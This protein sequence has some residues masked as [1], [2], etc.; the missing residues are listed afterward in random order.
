MRFHNVIAGRHDMT[1]AIID[2]LITLSD[3]W[4]ETPKPEK[5]R[6]QSSHPPCHLV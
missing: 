4:K 5:N 6:R 2:A 3:V 1:F